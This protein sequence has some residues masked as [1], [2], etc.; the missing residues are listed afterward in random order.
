MRELPNK[1]YCK[2]NARLNIKSFVTATQP[3]MNGMAPGKAPTKTEMGAETLLRGVY[4]NTYRIIESVPK[5]PLKK[6][7]SIEKKTPVKAHY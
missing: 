7:N 3:N 1:L 4:A 2:K 5:K 6:V